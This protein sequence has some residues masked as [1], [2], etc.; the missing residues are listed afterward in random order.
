MTRPRYASTLLLLGGMVVGLAL[1]EGALRALAPHRVALYVPD[2]VLLYRLRP[3]VRE[4]LEPPLHQGGA[5]VSFRVNAAGFRGPE[6]AGA[7]PRRVVVYGDSFVESRFTP[8]DAT[9]VARLGRELALASGAAPEVVN[10]G[11]T[12][13][14]PDQV[15]L[16]MERELGTLRPALVVAALFAGNDWGDP[17][18]NQLFGLDAQGRLQRRA[19]VLDPAQRALVGPPEGADALA[20]V[21]A[22]RR[23]RRGVREGPPAPPGEPRTLAWALRE[24]EDEYAARASGRVANLFVDH[25]DAD[26]A[27]RPE[28]ESARYKRALLRALVARMRE[29]AA[30]ARAPLLLLAIPDYRDL[31][32]APPTGTAGDGCPHRAEARGYPGYRPSALTDGLA[33]I[34]RAEGVPLLDLFGAFEGRPAALFHARDGHWNAE[35]QALAARLTA[36]RIA[37]GGWLR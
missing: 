17:V 4:T 34:A 32:A 6:L 28:S 25:Y 13:Y 24:C 31:C 21:R 5:P 15:A 23:L 33:E 3:G 16:R 12:G 18:R 37:E 19:A 14:G 22:L 30:R 8:E 35:G 7:P 11:V 1:V 26:V 10:A 2:D 36:A 29:E 27:L 9:F 20:I